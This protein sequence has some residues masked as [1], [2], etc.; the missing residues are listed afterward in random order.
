MFAEKI[1]FSFQ[2]GHNLYRNIII[3]FREK[4][5]I[6][7]DETTVLWEYWIYAL[8]IID[9]PVGIKYGQKNCQ[10]IFEF[11]LPNE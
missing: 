2:L 10:E 5:R 4:L 8:S 9:H 7:Q 3:E 11:K 1:T 6:N